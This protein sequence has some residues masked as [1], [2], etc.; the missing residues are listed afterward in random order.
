MN[1][2][3]FLVHNKR[4]CFYEAEPRCIRPYRFGDRTTRFA[5][6][7]CKGLRIKALSEFFINKEVLTFD[8]TVITDSGFAPSLFKT[9]QKRIGTENVFLY[10]MNPIGPRTVRFMH[11][12][13]LEQV[14]SYDRA[15][16][17]QHGIKYKHLPY[18]SKMKL[19]QADLC[20]DTFFLGTEKGRLEEIEKAVN[21]FEGY[22]LKPKVMIL[23]SSNPR[24]RVQRWV[25]YT[26]YLQYLA[27]AKTI[28]EINAEGQSSCTL[29]FLESLF[30][31]KKLVTNNVHIVED[32]YYDPANVFLLGVDDSRTLPEFV[33]Q[34]YK[35]PRGSLDKLL[36]ENWIQDW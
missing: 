20:C 23:S 11:Y 2:N 32:P 16:A 1:G 12:F 36:F 25:R 17:Q 6:A 18:S 3:A 35:E 29:R 14:Y 7:L 9:L 22:G 15:D 13:P 28:L 21:L 10:Y 4:D 33:A 34:P 31:R 8:K 27:S 26:E 5:L 24:Y 30:F 19:E